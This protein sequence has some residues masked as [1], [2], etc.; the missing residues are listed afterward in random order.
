MQFWK[1]DDNIILK[2]MAEHPEYD[3]IRLEESIKPL[4]FAFNVIR[5]DG[6]ELN[7]FE[8]PGGCMLE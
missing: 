7:L 1:I 3:S 4:E 2:Y 6:E 5:A 8:Y